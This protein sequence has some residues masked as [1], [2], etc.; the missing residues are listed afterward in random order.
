MSNSNK[1]DQDLARGEKI[2]RV[3]SE[4]IFDLFGSIKD[5]APV[6]AEAIGVKNSTSTEVLTDYSLGLMAHRCSSAS[7][8]HLR[9]RTEEHFKRISTLYQ[10]LEIPENHEIVSLMKEIN[11]SFEYPP[12]NNGEEYRCTIKPEFSHKD[13]RLNDSQVRS[14][15]S[16]ALAYAVQ[17]KRTNK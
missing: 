3:I 6:F 9:K 11:P 17:N 15:E 16:I 4:K 14:L 13:L 2:G 12:R 5:I 10:L 7:K 8:L 1:Y